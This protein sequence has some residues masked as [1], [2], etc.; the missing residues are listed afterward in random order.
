MSSRSRITVTSICQYSF[1]CGASVFRFRPIPTRCHSANRGRPLCGVRV[2]ANWPL[3]NAE[4]GGAE[5]SVGSLSGRQSLGFDGHSCDGLGGAAA[6]LRVWHTRLSRASSGPQGRAIS[7]LLTGVSQL[8]TW[9]MQM[10]A[11]AAGLETGAIDSTVPVD[12]DRAVERESAVTT[13]LSSGDFPEYSGS[14]SV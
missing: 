11:D 13:P 1:G 3:S 10:S 4:C 9:I 14:G 2:R 6:W 12:F 7:S 8:R 5:K